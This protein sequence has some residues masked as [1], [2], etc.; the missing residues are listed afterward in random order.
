MNANIY[1]GILI[2]ENNKFLLVQENKS[3]YPWY[4]PAG[5]VEAGEQLHEAA[6]RETLEEAGVNSNITGILKV[7]AFPIS[8][9]S[10]YIKTIFTGTIPPGTKLKEIPDEHSIKSQWFSLE[11]AKSLNLRSREVTDCIELYLAGNIHSLDIL[12]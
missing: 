9:E 6:L 2:E 11:E 8:E 7:D 5:R 10:Y 4:L 1:S 3:G 12:G